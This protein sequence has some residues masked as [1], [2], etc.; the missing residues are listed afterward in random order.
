VKECEIEIE[1]NTSPAM[2]NPGVTGDHSTGI[3]RFRLFIDATMKGGLY[4][5]GLMLADR[6][7]HGAAYIQIDTGSASDFFLC[8]RSQAF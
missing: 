2:D 3:L 4:W 7:C 8:R 1:K 5:Q 6:A